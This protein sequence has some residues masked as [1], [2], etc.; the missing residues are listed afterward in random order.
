M[1][2]VLKTIK[3]EEIY[4]PESDGKPMAETDVHR[5]QMNYLIESLKLF[6]KQ[7][8]N[9]VCFRQHNVLLRRRQSA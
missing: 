7:P 1:S 4:Y 9:R 6:F 3:R 2:A 5:E 8:K